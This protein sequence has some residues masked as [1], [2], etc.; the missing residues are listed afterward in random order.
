MS[1]ETAGAY[2]RPV[3]VDY[4]AFLYEGF[5]RGELRVQHCDDCGRHRHPPNPFCPYC[6]S[7]KWTA[8]PSGVRGIVHSYTVQHYPPIP[9]YEVPHPVVLVDM[10]GGFRLLAAIRG[11]PPDGIG[12]G[13]PVEARFVDLEPGFTLPVFF[14]AVCP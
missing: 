3:I 2:P 6:H 4:T 7:P 1:P 12:I 14:P 9:P 5:A 13:M 8:K 11:V 10:E